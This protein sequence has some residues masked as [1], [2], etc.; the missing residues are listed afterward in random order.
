MLFT[1]GLLSACAV[2]ALAD[3]VLITPSDMEAVQ[4]SPDF[5]LA[6]SP[7]TPGGS[8]LVASAD[9]GGTPGWVRIAAPPGRFY[10]Y[11]AWVRHPEGARDVAL[12]VG[13]VEARVDQRL[14]ANGSSPDDLPRDDMGGYEGLCNSGLYRLTDRPLDLRAGDFLELARSDTEAGK[15]STFAYAVFSPYLYLDDL[16]NDAC[17]AGRPMVNLKDYGAAQSAAWGGTG[18]IRRRMRRRASSGLSH[19]RAVCL[20]TTGTRPRAAPRT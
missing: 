5:A 10:V 6:E 15:V 7:Y 9:E 2:C 12:R 13:D 3:D 19:R 14:L 16:G 4:H 20:A 1:V 18:L 8:Y 11:V 17:F